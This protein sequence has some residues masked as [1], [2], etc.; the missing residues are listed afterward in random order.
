M[1]LK[2]IA[3]IAVSNVDKKSADAGRPVRLCNY[4]D[5]YY[6]DRITRD[7]DFM[8]ATASDSQ[9]RDFRL[10]PGDVLITKD[11]E[12]P[13][14][15][16]VPALVETS[17]EDLVCGYHLALIR[18]EKQ[19]VEPRFL[20]WTLTSTSA[21]TWF[22]TQ[23]TGVTR[24]GLRAQSIGDARVYLPSLNDQ[25]RI[26]DSLDTETTRIDA[27]IEKK[28]RMTEL[29]EVRWASSVR[30]RL[31]ELAPIMPLK[32]RWR[33]LDCKH[34]TPAYVDE[35]YPVTSPGDISPGRIDLSLCQRFVDDADFADLTEGRRPKRGDI[36]YSRNASAGIA[37]YVDTDAAFCMGQDVCLITSSE[38][39]QRFLMYALN[40]MGADQLEPIKVGSTITRI[41]VDQIGELKVPV[42]AVE[43]QRQVADALDL[44][45]ERIDQLA[46]RVRRQI[47]L[48][49]ERRQTLI[50]ASV[51]GQLNIAKAAA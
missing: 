49:G 38:Q 35:G 34:R 29:L 51:T 16:A 9:L 2:H 44:E 41:N 27:L 43:I 40:S 23:A 4:P 42:P 25:R 37:A 15:I 24:F 14:D 19:L 18:P 1:S 47:D 17:A 50:T 30:D 45:R 46:Q 28:R 10:C 8:S 7:L 12:T 3:R 21:R 36:I 48:L 5:V 31:N 22:S 26:A 39:D 20:F 13:D 33:V 32:R 11:S 6:N